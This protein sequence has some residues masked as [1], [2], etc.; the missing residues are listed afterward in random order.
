VLSP[1]ELREVIALKK[2]QVAHLLVK[3][4]DDERRQLADVA[5]RMKTP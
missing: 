1:E 5:E 2:E 4:R 3:L